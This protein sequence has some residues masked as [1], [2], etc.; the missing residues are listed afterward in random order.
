[1]LHA[2]DFLGYADGISMAR[3]HGERVRQGLALKKAGNE[4]LR[5]L[6]GREIHPVNVRAGGFY[7]AR[8]AQSWSSL[9]TT[10]SAPLILR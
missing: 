8:A 2:P 6:G 5:V 9:L 3:E 10:S 1:M 4:I 7:R